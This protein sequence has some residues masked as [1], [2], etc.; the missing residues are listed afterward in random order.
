MTLNIS[1][2]AWVWTMVT[3]FAHLSDYTFGSDIGSGE[4]SAMSSASFTSDHK[5]FPPTIPRRLSISRVL[6]IQPTIPPLL[7]KV[8]QWRILWHTK[9]LRIKLMKPKCRVTSTPST[10]FS[11]RHHS[12]SE[13]SKIPSPSPLPS[14]WNGRRIFSGNQTLPSP[15]TSGN[16][17]S[18]C[19]QTFR[20]LLNSHS[21]HLIIYD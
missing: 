10:V 17:I 19:E 6:T 11:Q 7:H 9:L 3:L 20:K 4:G 21:T 13:S 8:L 14:E 16:Y 15:S 2:L 1:T 18:N 5:S 12:S